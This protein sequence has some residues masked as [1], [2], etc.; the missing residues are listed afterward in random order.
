MTEKTKDP[1]EIKQTVEE[2]LNRII[3]E[4]PFGSLLKDA[5]ERFRGRPYHEKVFFLEM[6]KIGFLQSR[7]FLEALEA[8]GK[9][10]YHLPEAHSLEAHYPVKIDFE[11]ARRLPTGRGRYK[12]FLETV[13]KDLGLG[14]LFKMGKGLLAYNSPEDERTLLVDD[15]VLKQLGNPEEIKAPYLWKG[16]N[17]LTRHPS[18]DYEVEWSLKLNPAVLDMKNEKAYFPIIAAYQFIKG[19]PLGWTKED[20]D[21]F[22]NEFIKSMEGI[23]RMYLLILHSQDFGEEIKASSPPLPPPEKTFPIPFEETRIDKQVNDLIRHTH[24]IRLPRKW[25]QIPS[26]EKLEKQEIERIIEEEGEEAFEDL[27]NKNG[28]PNARGPL[29]RR[30]TRGGKGVIL[31]TSESEKLLK[32]KHG[33]GKGFRHV[34]KRDGKEYLT[35]LFQVGEGYLEIGFS[36]YGLA[37]PLV[38]EWRKKLEEDLEKEKE[39]T[40]LFDRLDTPEKAQV[41]R[42]LSQARALKDGRELME[43]IIGQVGPQG[44]NVV[45]I[46]AQSL[47]VLLEIENDPNWKSRVDSVLTALRSCEFKY[48]SFDMR[49]RK[50]NGEGS[51]LGEWD[52][53]AA[54]PGSHGDGKYILDVQQGFIGCLRIFETGKRKLPSGISTSIYDFGRKLSKDEKANMGSYVKF[55]NGRPYYDKAQGL[56][57]EQKNL[58]AFLE[59]EITLKRDPIP[60][61]SS[62]HRKNPS[63]KI[64]PGNTG[65]EEPRLYNR[66]FCPLLPEGRYYQAALGHFR[67][68]PESGRTLYG[69]R[70]RATETGGAHSEGLIAELGYFLPSGAAVNKRINI[71]R[72]SL[73]DFKAVVEEYLGG[74]IAARD[75]AGNWLTLEEASKLKTSIM[76]KELKWSFFLPETWKKD[77]EKKWEKRQRER[78]ERGETP[79][80]WKVSQSEE[81]EEP[82]V[83]LKNT[84]LFWRLH[85]VR[86]E[87][88]KS[89]AEVG[90]IFGVSQRAVS[91]WEKGT[92][93]DEEGRVPGKPIPRELEP[94]IL[95]WIET[96]EEPEEEELASRKTRRTG[97]PKEIS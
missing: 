30:G 87:R 7:A 11:K 12:F 17:Y 24:K 41:D 18:E 72:R 64:K 95:R 37:G 33:L 49:T 35:R 74:V 27:R 39:R 8:K 93:P 66:D 91:S 67:R 69:T 81:A 94:L 26:W 16:K 1:E 10:K 79:Y 44:G 65:A 63:Q 75:K 19:T 52:Y 20:R 34:D 97:L 83:G 68:N 47:R 84:P 42:L 40:P 21:T 82:K 85:A 88:E 5:Q 80:A 96:G 51:L 28:D 76:G 71:L 36:W 25:S 92:E 15:E 48:K 32:I 31:L 53:E 57:P 38:D 14:L 43:V 29:L 23:Q 50:R 78:A 22:W 4:E 46:E 58:H 9:G 73:E 62:Y 45:T 2:G 3:K 90:K 13:N 60:R 61:K 54:G 86:I 89:Q 70:T 77:R 59:R 55:N 6:I 56:T